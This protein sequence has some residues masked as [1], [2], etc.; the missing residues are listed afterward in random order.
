ML[1]YVP[2]GARCLNGGSKVEESNV[3]AETRVNLYPAFFGERERAILQ[4]GGLTASVWRYDGGSCGLKLANEV[5]EVVLLPFQGQQIWSANFEG[6]ELTM[7]SM[8]SE[9]RAT[10]NYL[11]NYGAFLLHCGITAT[12]VPA[13]GDTHPLHGELPN[14]PYQR[15]WLVAGE[16]EK[17][18]YI[19][20]SGEYEH[21]MAFNHHY[22]AQPRL[23]LRSGATLLEVDLAVT[24]LKRTE[25]ERMYLAHIN[26]RPVD[27]GRLVYSAPCT[28]EHARVRRSI[29]SHVHVKPG[30]REFL[31]EL[32]RHPEKHNL[33]TPDLVFD[34]EAVFSLDYLADENGW[35]H[36]MQAHPDGRADYVAHRPAELDKGIRWICRTPDQDALGIVLPATAEPEGYTAE[37]AKG[38]VKTL[39]PGETW[40][41]RMVAGALSAEE[42]K[43]MEARIAGILAG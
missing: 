35:A 7:R 30:Y 24:N 34:P 28:P 10:N 18:R 32:Q 11:Y 9:P 31:D 43:R 29:P 37:K 38:N 15:A 14:A 33:L 42:A 6:R 26:F 25:M 27:Y 17:G 16:D 12:G 8:F 13:A 41:C 21:V 22:V 5:G 40:S 4:D 20:V 23:K 2:G 19:G 3:S 36:T 39:G 1:G